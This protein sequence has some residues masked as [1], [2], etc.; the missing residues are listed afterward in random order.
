MGGVYDEAEAYELAF[1]YRNIA[2]EIDTILAWS[3]RH[4][5]GTPGAVLELAAGPADH[6]LELARRGIAA[7]AVDQ[8]ATMCAYAERR[9]ADR[10]LALDVVCADMTNFDIGERFDIALLMLNSATHLLTLDALL[11]TLSSAAR[12]VR[13]GG[14][15]VL[16]NSHPGDFLTP[17]SHTTTD[18]TARRPDLEVQV[19]WGAD[20]DPF[21]PIR[22]INRTTVRITRR[23]PGHPEV[24]TEQVMPERLWTAT[25]LDA[26][27]RLSGQWRTAGRYGTLSSPDVG[28]TDEGSWRMIHVLHRLA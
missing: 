21:D 3:G 11:A 23:R 14:I 25:E 18:W 28:L 6:A 24:T 15:F 19:Q 7:T 17:E 2:D 16:E 10:R 9:A 12:Q 4:G 8:N 22:Q 20:S 27:V 5:L 26:A 1:S 13:T